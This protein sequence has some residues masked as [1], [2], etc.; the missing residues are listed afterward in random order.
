MNEARKNKIPTNHDYIFND[1]IYANLEQLE[2]NK[3]YFKH[4]KGFKY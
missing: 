1:P 2:Y 3:F 4:H